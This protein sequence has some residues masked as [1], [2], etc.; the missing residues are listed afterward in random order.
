MERALSRVSSL[1][2]AQSEDSSAKANGGLNLFQHWLFPEEEGM[3][4]LASNTKGRD[5]T[6]A[7]WYDKNLNEEQRVSNLT[8]VAESLPLISLPSYKSAVKSIALGN[9]PVP[10]LIS[11]P[12][13][14]GKTKSA[15]SN[16]L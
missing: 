14:T 15:L 9:S 5:I 13:G 16:R 11:G 12:P 4:L 10:Y 8:V 7:Q 3:K 1:L 2:V 6:S